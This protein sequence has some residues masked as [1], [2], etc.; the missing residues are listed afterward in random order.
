[1]TDPVEFLEKLLADPETAPFMKALHD[2]AESY[3]EGKDLFL[4]YVLGG[5]TSWYNSRELM[6]VNMEGIKLMVLL[7]SFGV[8]MAE[9]E[10]ILRRTTPS[11]VAKPV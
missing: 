1:M 8:G 4:N 3:G 7:Q 10:G 5:I 6:I 2:K 9:V 11:E